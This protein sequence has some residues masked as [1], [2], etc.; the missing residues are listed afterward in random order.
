[1]GHRHCVDYQG[2][3][4]KSLD[5]EPQSLEILAILVEGFPLRRAQ[6]QC[7]GQ[8]QPLRRS[9]ATLE[10]ANEL[11]VQHS[12]MSGMLVNQDQAIFVLEPDVGSS[13]LKQ[14]RDWVCC[15]CDFLARDLVFVF[16]VAP[17]VA[18]GGAATGNRGESRS[19]CG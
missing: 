1:M 6:M 3:S 2:V 4:A 7:Q 15:S 14:D 13:Q 18:A 5:L 12:F 17:S 16:R 11:F 8:Q 10:R 9:G 19:I